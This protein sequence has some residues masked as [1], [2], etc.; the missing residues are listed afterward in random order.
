MGI[1]TIYGKTGDVEGRRGREEETQSHKGMQPKGRLAKAFLLSWSFA[2]MTDNSLLDI[3]F[4]P[5][6]HSD[7]GNQIRSYFVNRK[8]RTNDMVMQRWVSEFTNKNDMFEAIARNIKNNHNMFHDTKGGMINISHAIELNKPNFRVSPINLSEMIAIGGVQEVEIRNNSIRESI[9]QSTIDRFGKGHNKPHSATVKLDILIKD[10]YGVDE[11]D[12][13]NLRPA[14]LLGR[15]AIAALW[16]LQHQRGY[17]PF[18]NVYHYT[19]DL[20]IVF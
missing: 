6:S 14:A 3:A 4:Q 11:D 9:E 2:Q 7:Y 18:I 20:K 13:M 8:G 5:L 15:K 19:H 17:K 10:W 12:F 16:V 1:V